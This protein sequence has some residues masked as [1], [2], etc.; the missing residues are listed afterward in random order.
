MDLPRPLQRS[1]SCLCNAGVIRKYN[2]WLQLNTTYS[3]EMRPVVQ[4]DE[5]IK[6]KYTD[7]NS[8]T[9]FRVGFAPP[10]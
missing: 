3:L 10:Q 6:L 9:S 4:K 7:S 1:L 5:V 2:E 8:F